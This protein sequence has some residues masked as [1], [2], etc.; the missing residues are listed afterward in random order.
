MADPGKDKNRKKIKRV[1]RKLT[2]GPQQN[3]NKIA[4]YT[5]L[6]LLQTRPNKNEMQI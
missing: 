4:S 6:L 5:S 2:F 3:N 1:H